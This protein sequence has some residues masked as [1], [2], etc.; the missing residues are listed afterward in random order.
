V[1]NQKEVRLKGQQRFAHELLAQLMHLVK[2]QG[3]NE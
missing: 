1:I 3:E 2:G